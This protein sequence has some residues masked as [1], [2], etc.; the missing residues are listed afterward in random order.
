MQLVLMMWATA[1]CC[2]GQGMGDTRHTRC[3]ASILCLVHLAPSACLYLS[4]CLPACACCV[5]TGVSGVCPSTTSWRMLPLQRSAAASCGSGCA[6][7]H[8]P[9]RARPSQQLGWRSCWLRRLTRSGGEGV[10]VANDVWAPTSGKQQG[11]ATA[12]ALSAGG[13]PLAAVKTAP[14]VHAHEH[15][16]LSRT[17]GHLA[18]CC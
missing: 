15:S 18:G 9:Q 5:V 7:G 12:H 10:G 6:T 17:V 14:S 13:R 8:A 16:R 1:A 3:S 4:I 11:P 2:R